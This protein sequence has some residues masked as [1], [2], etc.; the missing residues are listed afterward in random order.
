[1]HHVVIPDDL[2]RNAF[3]EALG[4]PP[5]A[6]TDF[7]SDLRKCLGKALFGALAASGVPVV[8]DKPVELKSK[9]DVVVRDI[10]PIQHFSK[11]HRPGMCWTPASASAMNS[12]ITRSLRS[13]T[14][15]DAGHGANRPHVEHFRVLRIPPQRR[16]GARG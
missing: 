10:A 8:D 3:A 11:R 4:M 1:M 9:R 2:I 14:S 7:F 5:D 16:R 13:I 15:I 12:G 6:D